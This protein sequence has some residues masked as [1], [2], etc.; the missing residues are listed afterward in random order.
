MTKGQPY[1][2]YVPVKTLDTEA[3]WASLVDNIP[4]VSSHILV[5]RS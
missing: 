5:G 2:Q 1:G 4:C 3:L